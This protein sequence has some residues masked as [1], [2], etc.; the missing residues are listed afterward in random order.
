LE[1]LSKAEL[2]TA[3]MESLAGDIRRELAAL[4]RLAL[5]GR[6]TPPQSPAQAAALEFLKHGM[7]KPGP[8]KDVSPEVWGILLAVLMTARLGELQSERDP[9]EQSLLWLEDWL[10]GKYIADALEGMGIDESVARRGVDLA[11]ALV[12]Y[13]EWC[14]GALDPVD[15]AAQ[16]LTAWQDDPQVRRLLKVNTYEG[17]LWFNQ[18]SFDELVWRLYALQAAR[19]NAW[20][21][22]PL[23]ELANC[24]AVVKELLAAEAQSGFQFEKLAPEA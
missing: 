9:I 8:T 21:G 20:A 22:D 14:D 1:S 23:E 17:V 5:L 11:G 7:I 2:V 3:E 4:L 24:H 6:E 13:Q 15:S 12:R 18:E 16:L 19:L 10:F